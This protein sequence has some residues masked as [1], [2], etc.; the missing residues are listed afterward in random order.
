VSGAA[1]GAAG[2]WGGVSMPAFEAGFVGVSKAAAN[3]AAAH[4][5]NIIAKIVNTRFIGSS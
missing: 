5:M 2:F 4:D 1:G 3:C